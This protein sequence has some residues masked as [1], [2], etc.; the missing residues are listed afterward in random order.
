MLNLPPSV[1]VYVATDITDM[2]KSID[3]LSVLVQEVLKKDPFSGHLFVFCNKRGDKIK[4]LYWDR[5]GFCLWYKRLERGVFR[6]PKVQA[7]VFMIMPNELSLLLEG[8]DLT[9][10]NRL[11]AVEFDTIK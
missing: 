5:N 1:K 2:R 6:L 4:I 10:K 9:D 11:N 7:K 8:V 3:S